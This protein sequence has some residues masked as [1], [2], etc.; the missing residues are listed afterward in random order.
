MNHLRLSD[1]QGLSYI[2]APA[3]TWACVCVCVRV[4]VCQAGISACI[5]AVKLCQFVVPTILSQTNPAKQWME[6]V[7]ADMSHFSWLFFFMCSEILE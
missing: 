4:C 2:T 5:A 6:I 1:I 3:D 7:I